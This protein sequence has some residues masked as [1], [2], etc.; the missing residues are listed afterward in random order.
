MLVRFCPQKHIVSCYKF[1]STLIFGR[2]MILN[3]IEQTKIPIPCP[4]CKY[5]TEISFKDACLE[6]AYLCFGCRCSIKIK[7]DGKT[8]AELRSLKQAEQKML[9]SLKKSFKFKW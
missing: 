1:I 3:L 8:R 9:R 5:I 7:E 6:I 2:L 4:N